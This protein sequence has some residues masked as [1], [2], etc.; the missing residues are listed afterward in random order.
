MLTLRRSR[1]PRC[2]ESA[3]ICLN[4]ANAGATID[5][6]TVF[7]HGASFLVQIDYWQDRRIRCNLSTDTIAVQFFNRLTAPR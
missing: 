4:L 2:S 7:Y 5:S 1:A 6:D 3:L